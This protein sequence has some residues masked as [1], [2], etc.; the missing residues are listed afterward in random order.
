MRRVQTIL[1]SLLLVSVSVA[2]AQESQ[3]VKQTLFMTFVPNVQFSPVYAA[4]ENGH[5]A[6]NGIVLE[7]E[8]G[9]EN[10]G[11]DLIAANARQFGL[12]SGEEIIKARANGRPVVYVYEWFQKYPVGIVVSADSDIESVGDLTGRKVGI[13]GRFGASF[14]GLIALLS[15]NDMQESDIQ[16]EP[17]GFNA[18]EVFCMGGVEASVVYINNEPL[19]IQQ[20][21]ASGDCGQVSVVKVFPVSDAADMV[22][23]GLVTNE[24][25]IAEQPE[26]VRGMVAAFDAGLR[27]VINN[28]AQ[29]YLFSAAYVENLPMTD[30]FRDA[31]EVAAAA[32]EEFLAANP[33]RAAVAESRA[34]LL[35]TLTAGFD[36]ATLIQFRVLLATIDLW[37]ANRLGYSEASSWDVTQGVLIDMEF[38]KEPIDLSLAFT[39]EFVPAEGG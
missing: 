38:L 2:G 27:D 30:A 24:Q 35:G 29:A 20:R 37:D 5:M 17:I 3:S 34:A 13:P 16:L 26:L 8:H 6:D 31:L 9:D 22:S 28:P 15:A 25:T 10:V 21:A 33:N 36:D 23:N 11:V 4:I 19:Q 14:N 32:Q 18:P 39:N 12:V 7:I 1:L